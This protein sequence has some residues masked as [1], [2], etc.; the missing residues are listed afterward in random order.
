MQCYYDGIYTLFKWIYLCFLKDSDGY[1]YQVI[2]MIGLSLYNSCGS[3]WCWPILIF[4][5]TKDKILY[6]QICFGLLYYV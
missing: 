2:I 3:D 5:P 4:F 6:G 1:D